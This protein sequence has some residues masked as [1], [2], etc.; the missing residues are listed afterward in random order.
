MLILAVAVLN[1]GVRQAWIVPYT[2]ETAGRAI[3][4]VMLSA[5]IVVASWLT[6]RWL[7][8]ATARDAWSIGGLWVALTLAFEFLAGHYLFGTPWRQ[9][10]ADYD[11]ASGRI[12]VLVL[13]T[14]A[15]APRLAAHSRGLLPPHA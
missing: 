2:G 6:I 10:L 7:R 14:T 9:L 1:G 8:P 5:A 13:V 12:W 4:S 15:I 3:S 11:V